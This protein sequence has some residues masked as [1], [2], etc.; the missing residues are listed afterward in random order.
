MHTTLYV[1]L[2]VEQ[3]QNTNTHTHERE[4]FVWFH[5]RTSNGDR[6]LNHGCFGVMRLMDSKDINQT[7]NHIFG[8]V[9]FTEY[10]FKQCFSET[11]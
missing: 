8:S 1:R 3:Q 11:N 6:N 10:K 7:L 4:Y 5:S 2:Y 9:F